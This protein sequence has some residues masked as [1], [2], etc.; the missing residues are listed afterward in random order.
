MKPQWV[1][2]SLERLVKDESGQTVMEYSLMVV[3]VALAIATAF[4]PVQ[5]AITTVFSDIQTAL[6][7]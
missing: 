4:P 7:G 5:N 2:G 1:R 3:L 6:G